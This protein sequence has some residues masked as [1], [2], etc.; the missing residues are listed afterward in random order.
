MRKKQRATVTAAKITYAQTKATDRQRLLKTQERLDM[1]RPE[2][3]SLQVQTT[4]HPNPRWFH[5][6]VLPARIQVVEKTEWI[7]H[8]DTS[9][10]GE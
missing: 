9:D 6:R 4:R 10:F 1:E 3:T 2:V 5:T 8:H 7:R